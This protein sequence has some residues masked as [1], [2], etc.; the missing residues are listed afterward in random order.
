MQTILDWFN[1]TWVVGI[2]GGILSG[3]IVN[4]VSRLFL[5]KKENREYLQKIFSANRE[6]IYS[7]RPGISE[8]VIPKPETVEALIIA[9][10][11][12]Y[13][14]NREDVYGPP[15]ITQELTK[16]VM[17]SSFISSQLKQEYCDRLLS[18]IPATVTSA[19]GEKESSTPIEVRIVSQQR[20]ERTVERMSLVLGVFTGLMSLVF[21]MFTITKDTGALS[22]LTDS[23]ERTGVFLPLLVA[24]VALVMSVAALPIM[25]ELLE[26]KRKLRG[27]EEGDADS[28]AKDL[29]LRSS[30]PPPAAAELK[31]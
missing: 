2:L 12:K 15:E 6:V 16:E 13:S 14:V 25:K 19:T 3:L 27:K 21:A 1:N 4:Y 26:V 20:R 17:D 24:M 7:I 5:S 11:R 30:G 23:F 18:I 22:K 29:T 8:G 9:T 31:R 10:A 28:E